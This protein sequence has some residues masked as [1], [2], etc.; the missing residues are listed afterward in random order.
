MRLLFNVRLAVVGCG[1]A[2]TLAAQLPP[3]RIVTPPQQPEQQQ[4]PPQPPKPA[5][6]QGQPANPNAPA[7]QPNA[8]TPGPLTQVGQAPQEH[9]AT[10]QTFALNGVSL[11]EMIETIARQLKI[12]YILDPRVKGSVII[13]TFGEVKPVDL[14]PLLQTILRINGMAMVQV[15]D[16][17]RIVPINTV[18]QLPLDPMVNVDPKTLPDDERMILN[19]VFL[20]YATAGEL[21]SLIKPFLGE[22]A[23]SQAY[24]PA[25]LLIIEDNS[26]SMKRTMELIRLFD[27]DTF[28]GQR[29]KLFDVTNSR[30][31]DIQKELD[32]VFKAYALSEK[33]AA[34]KFIPVDRINTLIA[35]APN[36]GIFTEVA[37]WIEKLDIPVKL[38]AGGVNNYVYRLKY[39]RAETVAMAIMALYSGNVMAL[40]QLA[41]MA[42][43]KSMMGGMGGMYGG[44]MGMYGGGMGYGSPYGG[45]GG[46]GGG[47][48]GGMGMSPYA[49]YGGF[50]QG[51]MGT[52]AGVPPVNAAP[53]GVA[54]P[55]AAPG[56]NSDLTGL[57]LGNA[58]V[59]QNGQRIPRVVPNPFDNTLLVQGTPQEWE[60]INSLLRQLDVPPRQVLI[61][62]KIYELDLT[63]AFSAGVQSFL[64]KKDA[65][66]NSS[67]GSTLS[68]VLNATAG[69]NGLTLSAGAL[70]LRSHELL[71]V[72][73][74]AESTHNARVISAPS[75]IATDSIPAVMN[76]G[77]DV[78]VLT[79]SGVAV[80]GSSFNSV[81]NRSTG[82]T[83]NIT[84]RVNSSG[85]VTLIV[86]QDVSEP[87]GNSTSNID[88][89]S[90]S[91]RSFQTQV[92]V[93]DGDT[94]AVGG[95]IG[96]SR[97]NDSTGVPVLHRIP[98]LG[99]A[100]GSKSISRTRTELII[101]ITPRVLYD[102]NQI[103]EAT[104]E[105]KNNLKRIQRMMS[106]EGHN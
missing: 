66:A 95:F 36:P 30:P 47:M 3:V 88:S 100:F 99:A 31:S 75:I 7:A 14:M 40:A 60:Q 58:N 83:M 25:N 105:I 19:L 79:S 43:M 4:P 48:Y 85:V 10:T 92:T 101:F 98:I 64:E 97:V 70:V 61:D 50:T 27:A 1:L 102:T 89:P 78:P 33:T 29:V 71:G 15:G 32:S 39:G 12:S 65:Q 17:Y 56:P 86:D 93:Q 24:E 5:Q 46:M 44:G 9:L 45:Y 18:S 77:E 26:R 53:A 74:T 76:V 62:A 42:Q 103:Q 72:L 91:R 34:V 106:N 28:A 54:N 94:V 20:K 90:F 41:S 22:G 38:S 68:R 63:G 81:S 23:T 59:G 73:N 55:G 84:A 13:Y 37:N 82:V 11:T 52:T 49:M 6:P 80:T 21:N 57:A 16:L 2:A 69:P 8:A 104:D 96:E 35:V 51:P 67:G 87:Q